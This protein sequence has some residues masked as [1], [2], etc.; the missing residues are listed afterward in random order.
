MSKK[1]YTTQEQVIEQIQRIYK[2]V[3]TVDLNEH[4]AR[5]LKDIFERQK[6]KAPY[7]MRLDLAFVYFCSF[8]KHDLK[9]SHI[10][11]PTCGQA[12]DWIEEELTK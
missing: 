5:F 3:S 7:E 11:C 6:A 1:E 9:D 12:I 8:C 10:Y 2:K 4:E